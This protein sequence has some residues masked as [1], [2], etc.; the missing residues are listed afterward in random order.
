MPRYS[1]SVDGAELFYRHYASEGRAPATNPAKSLAL[2]Y[3]HQWLLSS[4][5]YDSIPLSLCE[6]HG[7]RVIAHDRRGFGKS[8]W[9]G[10]DPS[11]HWVQGAWT[12]LGETA[13]RSWRISIAHMYRITARPS[14]IA[15]RFKGPFGDP[16][17]GSV[18]EKQVASF[19]NIFSEADPFAVERCQQIYSSED[20]AEDLKRFGH[21]FHKH[22]L[23]IHGVSD[24][25]VPAEVSAELVQ[26]LVPG[27]KL[28]IYAEG[29]HVLVLAYSD[30]LLED[31]VKFTE[32]ITGYN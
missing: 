2:I 19:E 8:D 32:G 26:E 15:N 16:R 14:F 28:T 27:A 17:S 24:K 20:L 22:F 9:F 25:A 5:M 13:K 21:N 30:R 6:T 1:S 4:R 7:C 23:L 12:R 18:T 11:F 29:G 31:I 3:L 10:Q